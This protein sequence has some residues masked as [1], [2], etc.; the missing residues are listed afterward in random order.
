[1]VI[2]AITTVVCHGLGFTIS[3]TSANGIVPNGT[4]Y[5]WPIP[6]APVVTGAGAG[7][8]LTFISATALSNPT[9]S[10]QSV[11]YTITPR[12]PVTG[13]QGTPFAL[14]VTVNPNARINTFT[15]TTCS[16]ILFQVSPV[17]NVAGN[18]VPIG[19]NYTWTLPTT[20]GT[21][22]GGQSANVAQPFFSAT[23][24]NGTNDVQT[25]TY[26]VTPIAPLCGNS[27]SFTIVVSVERGISIP[28]MFTTVCS[29]VF[30]RLT[31]TSP[32]NGFILE[33]TSYTWS[34][35]TG[36]GFSGGE[37]SSF[38]STNISGT[39]TNLTNG[40]VTAVYSVTA[41]S[42]NC[43]PLGM[44]SV[45][46]TLRPIATINPLSVTTCSGIAF[47]VSPAN[48]VNGNI[49]PMSTT[50][51]WGLPSVSPG[52]TGGASGTNL[53]FISGT[54]TN[55]TNSVRT[56]VYLVTPA[57][58]NCGANN[59]FTVT[60]TVDP[61]TIISNMTAVVC[62]GFGFTVTPTNG[63]NGIIPEGTTF[64]W[65]PPIVTGGMTGG[66]SGTDAVNITNAALTHSASST[67]FA[68]YII[69]PNTD[70]CSGANPF[71][72]TVTVNPQANITP[73][74]AVACGLLTFTVT[75][76]DVLNGG[77]PVGTMYTWAAPTGSGFSGG[78]S[79]T[80]AQNNI[81]G[82]L[83]NTTAF[84]TTA[85]YTVSTA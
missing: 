32:E 15:V 52:L 73:M 84:V 20:T 39:L 82:R 17:N 70:V 55:T 43:G 38:S 23:L 51:S 59:P 10:Q 35:P 8:N 19:T 42:S 21:I 54:L 41:S 53:T 49:V 71:V 34:E 60:V 7:T 33:N 75:P 72:L 3:P 58:I 74:T 11:T 63:V 22:S 40:L 24:I 78:A 28:T 62:T 45:V 77:V 64:T 9:N 25:A 80:N 67:Q 2:S 37:A 26:T 31:P 61:G 27:N 56:A 57:T 66:Q 48:G 50:Y 1:P 18:I 47:Q 12:A 79:Q 69:T 46:V 65:G 4:T 85:V 76:T 13:C 16:G 81:S 44:F 36:N 14:T 6:I 5:S 30:F 68:T 29:G 83:T